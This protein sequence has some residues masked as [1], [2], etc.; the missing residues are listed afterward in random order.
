MIRLFSFPLFLI[1]RRVTPRQTGAGK[2]FRSGESG[3]RV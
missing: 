1:R 2:G 3:N